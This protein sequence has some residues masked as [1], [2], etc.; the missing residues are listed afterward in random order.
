MPQKPPVF[1][2]RSIISKYEMETPIRSFLEKIID[3]N[4][5][6]NLVSRE[7][8]FEELVRIAADSLVP[9]EFVPPPAG[10]FYDIGP[11]AGFPSVL[12]LLAFENLQG[13]LIERTAKK[14][15]FLRKV[16]RD[17]DL[18]GEVIEANF[19]EPGPRLQASSFDY[20]FLKLIKLDKKILRR[21]LDLLKPEGSFIYYSHPDHPFLEIPPVV[22]VRR[23]AYYL[24]DD[25]RLRTI[26]IFS[27][28]S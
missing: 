3:Y 2:S 1:D 14:A 27:L 20:G 9:F 4:R 15:V 22:T 11:G 19:I 6:V 25:S 23:C 8:S 16:I 17:F 24:D 26:S 7:T 21:S 13:F 12:L 10:R 5:K 28:S 18:S